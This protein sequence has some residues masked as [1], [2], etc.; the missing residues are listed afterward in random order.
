MGTCP[1]TGIIPGNLLEERGRERHTTNK[2]LWAAISVVLFVLPWFLLRSGKGDEMRPAELWV[3]FFRYPESAWEILWGILGL[4]LIF[5]IPAVLIGWVLQAMIVIIRDSVK[6]DS[7][8][9]RTK[10]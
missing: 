8:H 3:E 5:A 1:K 6:S 2:R 10:V 9:R 4:S 7:K